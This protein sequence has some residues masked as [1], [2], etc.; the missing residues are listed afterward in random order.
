MKIGLGNDHAALDMKW[1]IKKYLE[2]QGYEV[3][4]YGTY[5]PESCDYPVYGEKVA[6]A[7]V[8]K[9]VDYGILMCGTGIGISLAANKVKGIR[10]AVCSEPCSARLSRQHNNANILA[11]GARIVGIEEAKMI[12][13]EWLHAE[14]LGGR[15]AKR[16]DMITEIEEKE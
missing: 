14:F 11:M 16:V 4:D 1:E 10:A 8:A 15:H 2:D 13:D 6:R 7:V 12:V 3:V 9:E 5:T